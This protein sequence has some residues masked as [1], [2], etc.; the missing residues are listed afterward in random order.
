MLP[1]V[2][3]TVLR[4]D[5]QAALPG[6][7][8]AAIRKAADAVQKPDLQSALVV[9]QLVPFSRPGRAG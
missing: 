5:H 4:L 6:P 2:S 1:M 8:L 3:Q 7:V 9:E